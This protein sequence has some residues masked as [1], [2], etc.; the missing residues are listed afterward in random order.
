MAENQKFTAKEEKFC[1]EY[2]KDFNATQAA[3]RAKYSKASAKEIGY[4]NL[5]K[6]HIKNRIDELSDLID[7]KEGEIKNRFTSIARTDM[8]DYLVKKTETYTPKEEVGLK[9][10]IKR[11]KAE[12]DFEDDYA[13]EVN[14]KGDELKQHVKEQEYRRRQAI[15]YKLELKRNPKAFR[16]VDGKTIL[17]ETA[18]LDIVKVLDD[19]ERGVIKSIKHTKD[20]I[21][22]EPYA[23]DAALNTLAKFKGM[24]VDKVATEIIN[25]PL[26]TVDPLSNIEDATTDHSAS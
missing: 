14:L 20:G 24:I 11:I 18:E 4:E 19:K 8:K 3:I 5:T 6:P 12:I 7:M 15:R 1:H 2:I 23:A 26:M 17:I 22:I 21:Q 10:L 13:L 16:I 25:V 9:E